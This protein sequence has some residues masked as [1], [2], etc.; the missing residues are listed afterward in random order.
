VRLSTLITAYGLGLLIA[1]ALLARDSGFLGNIG[2][3]LIGAVLGIYPAFII[4][5]VNR[6]RRKR[7]LTKALF[8]ELINRAARCCFDYE[9]PWQPYL[10]A[11]PK[12]PAFQVR[13]FIPEPPVIYPSVAADL[14]LLDDDAAKAIIDFY[15]ALAAWRRDIENLVDEAHPR[16][17]IDEDGM[18]LLGMRL[19]QTLEPARRALEALTRGVANAPEIERDALNNLD[20]IFPDQHPNAGVP[21]RERL[22]LAMKA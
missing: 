3:L 22:E 1:G 17:L 12:M 14:A 9:A 21:L 11:P 10:R 15:I 7:N 8:H 13:K 16:G 6:A 4:D 20:A 19:R 2:F 18:R 5:E